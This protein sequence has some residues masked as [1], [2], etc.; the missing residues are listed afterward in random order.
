MTKFEISSLEEAEEAA[1]E[2]DGDG[3]SYIML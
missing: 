1:N 3:E 2:Y